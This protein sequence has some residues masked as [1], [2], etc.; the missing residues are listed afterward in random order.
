M[1]VYVHKPAT[2]YNKLEES[3]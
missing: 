1:I 3:Y 2:A